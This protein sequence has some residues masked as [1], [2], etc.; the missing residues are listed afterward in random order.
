VNHPFDKRVIGG[1]GLVVTLVLVNAGVAYRNVLEL[2]DDAILVAHTHE[3]L[4]ALDTLLSAAKDAETGERGF[5]ITGDERYLEP[6]DVAVFAL[7]AKLAEVK[8]LTR[9][10]PRQQP[11]IPRLEELLRAKLDE[12]TATISL[13]RE[14]GFEAAEQEVLT[15]L[16]KNRMDAIRAL[17][18]EMTED[19]RALLK[20]REQASSRAYRI[21]LITS[22]LAAL[23]ALA[24]VGT[25][26]V[27]FNRQR[28][29]RPL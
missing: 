14:K 5:L 12:L 7:D 21:A 3:V 4:D 15:H 2:H 26:C 28:I 24:A 23:L 18:A 6:Y 16:G 27:F 10:N 1:L 22:F 11:R 25:L 17:V 20:D 13:R 8:Q 9:D 29:D 19:E